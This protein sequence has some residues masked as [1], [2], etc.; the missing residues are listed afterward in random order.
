M[1]EILYKN[2]GFGSEC[3]LLPAG[4][5]LGWVPVEQATAGYPEP[6]WMGSSP[7][8][9]GLRATGEAWG[10]DS[11]WEGRAHSP[12]GDSRGS[13]VSYGQ[14]ALRGQLGSEDGPGQA[15]RVLGSS[16]GLESPGQSLPHV[17]FLF[18][19]E[20]GVELNPKEFSCPRPQHI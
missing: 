19:I 15:S 9:G 16:W 14:E 6:A 11:S 18:I 2:F 4:P 10:S 7:R 20:V 12:Q 1:I 3:T 5:G 17:F 13:E 8:L